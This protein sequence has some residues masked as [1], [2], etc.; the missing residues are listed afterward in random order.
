MNAIVIC[1]A[2]RPEVGFLDRLL[3]LALIPV[4]GRPLLDLWLA[5]LAAQGVK[6]VRVIAADRPDRIRRFV[7][8]GEAWG[9][10]VEVVPEQREVSPAEAIARHAFPP[11]D[12]ATETRVVLLDHVPPNGPA[13]WENHA[14]WFATLRT[15]FEPANADRVGIRQ[16]SPGVFVH[17]R[18]RLSPDATLHP[19]CWIG[20]HSWIGP[21]AVIGPNTIIEAQSYVDEGA[22][23]VDSFVGPGT[24]VGALTEVRESIAWR[25]DLYKIPTGSST[26]IQ[27]A[28]LLGPAHAGIRRG[29]AA[30]LAGRLAALLLLVLS[31]PILI[32]AW[33]RRPSGTPLFLCHAAVRTPTSDPAHAG[34]I[35]YHQLNGIAGLPGR[36]PELWKIAQGHFRWVGNRP[37][38]PVQAE[39]LTT[40]YERLWLAVP[41]GLIS[42]ADAEGCE[43]AFGDDARAHSSFFSVRP[44]WRHRLTILWRTLQRT[45]QPRSTLPSP[46]VS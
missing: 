8:K 33:L 1:P 7:G 26:R 13:L 22:E 27:D 14:A 28:F 35:P 12:P 39:S 21:R 9:I 37:L 23:V 45:P 24:Y 6:Q 10:R 11:T 40:E 17:A 16:L 19:P 2:D 44:D 3:P 46:N 43:D 32:I 38:S 18:S 42:L 34:T 29:H 15:Q 30:S 5:H 4:L 25:R 36:W 20:A 31:S 41:T